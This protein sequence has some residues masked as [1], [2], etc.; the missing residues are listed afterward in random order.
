MTLL[1]TL[2]L[3]LLVLFIGCTPSQKEVGKSDSINEIKKPKDFFPDERAKVLAVGTFHFSYPGLDAFKAKESDKIDVL[4]SKRQEEVRE[5]ANYIKQFKP[6]KIAIEAMPDWNATEKL[7]KYKAGKIDLKRD[8]RYQLGIR[9]ATELNLD[10]LYP[11]DAGSFADK[12]KKVDS[13]FTKELFREYDFKSESRF[14]SMYTRW[15]QY[16][17]ELTKDTSLLE[18]FHYLNSEETHQY[19]YGAYLTGDFK[20]ENFR[21]ADALSA[22]WYNR[23]LRIFRKIQKMTSSNKDRILVIFGN[24][25][26][27]ILR[28]LLEASPEYKFVEF[29]GL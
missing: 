25:H 28:Q 16:N 9:I 19:A 12:L 6:N 22:Y 2:I 18:Y 15:Y 13:S 7:K 24:G 11:I 20:L 14:D 27:A 8:E 10:T 5:L 23:N 26:V 3:S 4:K 29:S 17:D 21:G 1:R